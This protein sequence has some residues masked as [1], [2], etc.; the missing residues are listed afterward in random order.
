LKDSKSFETLTWLANGLRF[1]FLCCIAFKIN[2]FTFYTKSLDDKNTIQNSGVSL[3]VEPVQFSTSKNQNP[4]F[5]LMMYYG[6]L[7]EI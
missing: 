1:G 5:G 4:T 2:N 3:E 6:I 7:E